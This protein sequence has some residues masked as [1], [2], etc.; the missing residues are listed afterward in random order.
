MDSGYAAALTLALGAAVSPGLFAI[1][2][3]ILASDDRP[4]ARAW[5]YL[6]GVGTVI[7]LSTFVGIVGVRRAQEA[8]TGVPLPLSVAVRVAAT[9]A[10][11]VLGWRTLR[12]TTPGSPAQHPGL[13]T[14]LRTARPPIFYILGVATMLT[15]WSTLLL[16]LGALEVVNASATS[17]AVRGFASCVVFLITVGP[18]LLPVVA[19]T[20]LGHRSE[21]ILARLGQVVGRHANQLIS[22]IYFL[23]AALVAV[24]AVQELLPGPR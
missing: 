16:Y 14:R 11:L 23:I 6:L 24:S 22:A 19:V 3:L 2:L 17:T 13:E 21:R 4:R 7:V 5:F 18:L 1:V 20:L 10:L 12:P 8:L 15:N 9:M